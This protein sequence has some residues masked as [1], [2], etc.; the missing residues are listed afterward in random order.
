MVEGSQTAAADPSSTAVGVAGDGGRIV[1]DDV[2]QDDIFSIG[3]VSIEKLL[4]EHTSLAAAFA[5]YD[6]MRLAATFGAL[7]ARPKLMA[8]SHR[9]EVLVHLALLTAEG[10]K[11]PDDRIVEHAFNAMSETFVGLREDPSEDVAVHNIGTAF[12]NFRMLNGT[13][14]SGG[15]Y[16]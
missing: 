3:S 16:L 12:G 11:K 7:L 9:L 15:F 10:T 1:T 14:E 8:N 13:W 6:R 4:A 2:D 5:P